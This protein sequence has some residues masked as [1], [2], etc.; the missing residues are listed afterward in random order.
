[1]GADERIE[2]ARLQYE[3]A[4]FGGDIAALAT[5]ERELDG[6]EADLALARGRLLHARFLQDREE[7]PG[8]LALFRRAAELYR[9]LGDARGEG[10]ALF[11]VGCYHQVVRRADAAAVPALERSRELAQRA[12]D[13]LTLSYALRHLGI[14]EHN[15]G[16][17]G[18]A[19][20]RL[21]ESVRQTR[22]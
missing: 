5:A 16:R 20:G 18:A 8:E 9:L 12:G 11:R 1:M 6:V 3:R 7:D 22:P 17:L 19:R 4:V 21:E 2:R 13:A 14:A 10:E 15:A